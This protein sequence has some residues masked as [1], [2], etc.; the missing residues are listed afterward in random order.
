MSQDLE[1]FIDN[2]LCRD[3]KNFGN[4]VGIGISTIVIKP[5]DI[6]QTEDFLESDLDLMVITEEKKKISYLKELIPYYIME[7]D[8]N[9][10]KQIKSKFKNLINIV[11][12]NNYH[13]FYT[14]KFQNIDFKEDE[15]VYIEEINKRLNT[16]ILNT[17]TNKHKLNKNELIKLLDN[18]N[19]VEINKSIKT[20]INA[21]YERLDIDEI[22]AFD[23]HPKQ[24]L[25]NQYEE[26]ILLIDP[27]NYF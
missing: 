1:Y 6:Y 11:V 23:L 13:L 24:F 25:F 8:C 21:L 12:K 18:N 20:S 9:D 10:Y 4:I 22:K 14:T 5:Y 7:V 26:N 17:T 2:K 19:Y 27:I 3:M 16:Y 15:I